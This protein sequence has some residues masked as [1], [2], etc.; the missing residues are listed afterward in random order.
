MTLITIF[1]LSTSLAIQ[2]GSVRPLLS[3]NT[4]MK[5]CWLTGNYVLSSENRQIE[6][7]FVSMGCKWF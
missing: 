1:I 3:P 2:I 4:L 7:N 6:I 5:G